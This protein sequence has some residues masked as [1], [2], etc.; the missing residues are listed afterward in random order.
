[1]TSTTTCAEINDCQSSYTSYYE[2]LSNPLDPRNNEPTDERDARSSSPTDPT[3]DTVTTYTAAAQIASKTTPPTTACP[4]GCKT[5]YTYTAGTES[6]VG[7]GTEPAGLLK[8]VTSPNGGVTSYEYDSAGDVAQVTDP[9]R[10]VTAYTHD[11]LGR[12]LSQTQTSDTYPAGLTTSYTYDD[13]DQVVTETDPP[14]TDRVTGV[15]HTE[16]TSRTYDPDGDTLTTT[17]SDAT[18]GDASRT[19][20]DTYDS[21]GNLASVT[22]ALGNKTT[23]TYDALG[24]RV[25]ETNPA[26]VTTDYTYDAAGN[27]LTTTLV[28]YTGNPSDPIAAENLVQDSRTYDPAGRLASD[29]NV[30]GT[31]TGYTY[32]GNGRIASSFVEG[33]SGDVDVYT[34]AYDAAGNEVSSTAPGALVTDTAYNA[35]GQVTSQ[36]VDPTGVDR[37]TTAAYDPDGNVADARR[38]PAAG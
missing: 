31:T 8:T 25:S 7:G 30:V 22:D 19:T 36:T 33:P 13:Q 27:L 6:A 34:Y 24:D 20:T 5:A 12:Q 16:V 32:Y 35:D 10:L 23:Y 14:V 26:G 17:V 18:G 15:V 38:C 29:T 4:S 21:H 9:L 11:N 1:M 3:Y 28:G 37:V 2:D